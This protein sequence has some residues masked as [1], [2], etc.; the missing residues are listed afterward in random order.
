MQCT[1]LHRLVQGTNL[2]YHHA[3]TFYNNIASVPSKRS[4]ERGVKTRCTCQYIL[5]YLS[6]YLF[7]FTPPPF[8][9]PLRNLHNRLEDD[10]V[11]GTAEMLMD[12]GAD[13]EVETELS[14]LLADVVFPKKNEEPGNAGGWPVF[15]EH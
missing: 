7:I 14:G 8:V 5:F 10:S 6:F 11:V 2:L 12:G 4:A 1:G 15:W 3:H 13:V 9:P